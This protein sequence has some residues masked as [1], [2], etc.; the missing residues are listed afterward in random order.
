MAQL[1]NKGPHLI[2]LSLY[3]GQT[4]AQILLPGHSFLDV[5][6]TLRSLASTVSTRWPLTVTLFIARVS[7]VYSNLRPCSATKGTYLDFELA[8]WQAG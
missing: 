2:E 4:R 5:V 8:T 3:R 1:V 7:F 6:S